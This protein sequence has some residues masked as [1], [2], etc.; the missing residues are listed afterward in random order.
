MS[1]S[2]IELSYFAKKKK[3]VYYGLAAVYYLPE[4]S[5]KAM[6]KEY[7]AEISKTDSNYLKVK[8]DEINPIKLEFRKLGAGD[9][10]LRLDQLLL[11]K[12]LKVTGIDSAHLPNIQWL[13]NICRWAD[14]NDD[15]KLF[16][17]KI[18]LEATIKRQIDPR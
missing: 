6:S 14:P 3:D 2:L 11:A 13:A 17:R 5:S 18:P 16:K 4:F 1:A 9:L 12:G 7:L 15:L 8:N 10:I